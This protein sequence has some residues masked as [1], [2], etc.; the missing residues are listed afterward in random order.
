MID[1]IRKL[2]GF[3]RP[4]RGRFYLG[5]L[6]GVFYGMS[7]ALL[8]GVLR[9]VMGLVFNHSVNLQ[10]QM[11]KAPRLLK[12]PAHWLADRL[13]EFHA[14]HSTAG[15][16]LLIGAVPAVMLVR[17]T[18]AYLSIYLTNWAAMH[19]IADI[20]TKLFR[21]L[22]NLSL[23]FFSKNSTGDLIAR[24]TNDTQV[25][26]GIIGST[27]ASS[28]KDPVTIVCLLGSLRLSRLH[29]AD[30]HLR[31]QSPPVGPGGAGLQRR[32]DQPD[33]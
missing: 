6:C 19:A 7:Q 8:L 31:P 11:D 13:P 25:L 20:R 5:L 21:H 18:L 26:Y 33:A 15:W 22:Q 1:F 27:F 32:V 12:P 9:V 2:W 4:Y 28:V 3:V 30:C 24:I 23:G 14:P 16:V 10:G 29:R 17:V